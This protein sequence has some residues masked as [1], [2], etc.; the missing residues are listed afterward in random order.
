V[1][2]IK[3]DLPKPAIVEVLIEEEHAMDTLD[4]L[5]LFRRVRNI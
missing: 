4:T 3:G 5:K 1:V 2:P